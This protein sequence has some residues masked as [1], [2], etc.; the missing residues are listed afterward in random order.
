MVLAGAVATLER[1]DLFISYSRKDSPFV[2]ELD[3]RLQELK[4]KTWVDWDSV[5][6]GSEFPPKIRAGIEGAANFIFVISPDSVSSGWCQLEL[7]HAVENHKRL[8]SILYRPVDPMLLPEAIRTLQWIDFR[9]AVWDSALNTLSTVIDTDRRWLDRH[10]RILVR[11]V[12]WQAVSSD[13]LL[14]R[15]EELQEAVQWLGDAI[16]IKDPRPSPLQL[17]YIQ[18]SQVAQEDERRRWQQLSQKYLAGRLAAESKLMREE[19]PRLLARSVLLAIESLRRFP[20][21]EAHAA[22]TQALSL[23]PRP[24]RRPPHDVTVQAI[25]F[26]PKGS[27]LASADRNGRI[28]LTNLEGLATSEA[29]AHKG[30]VRAMSF[31]PDERFL[32]AASIDGTASVWDLASSKLHFV[33]DHDEAVDT[34]EF[35]TEGTLL[36]TATGYSGHPGVT[37]IWD[38]EQRQQVAVIKHASISRFGLGGH[39]MATSEATRLVLRNPRAGTITIELPHDHVVTAFD[40]CQR[41][42]ILAVV[43]FDGKL[44]LWQQAEQDRVARD[45]VAMAISPIGPV[46]LSPDGSKVAALRADSQIRVWDVASLTEVARIGYEGSVIFCQLAFDPSGRQVAALS[47]EGSSIAVWDIETGRLVGCIEQNQA[48]AMCFSPNGELLATASQDNAAWIWARPDPSAWNWSVVIGPSRSV[49]FSPDGSCLAWTG[50]RVTE[51]GRIVGDLLT[52]WESATGRQLGSFSD[53]TLIENV[54]F[55]PDGRLVATTSPEGPIHVFESM[56][57]TEKPEMISEAQQWFDSPVSIDGYPQ[58][59]VSPDG[60]LFADPV[61]PNP[62][63]ERVPHIVEVRTSADGYALKNELRFDGPP[64]SLAWSPDSQ[65]LASGH[66]DGVVRVWD[67][68]TGREIARVKF[69]IDVVKAL[70]FSPGGEWLASAGYDG[71]LVVWRPRTE[72]LMTEACS[73]LTRNLTLEEWQQY[74]GEEKYEETCPYLFATRQQHGPIA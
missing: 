55:S 23:L 11:A 44:W 8:I 62:G 53:V 33:V 31:S 69:H 47:G 28:K 20:S 56:T 1:F 16:G 34:V 40:V 14:L 48:T 66:V 39:I 72:D 19:S 12:E 49:R 36:L 70:A 24:I 29:F 43:T 73:R 54:A 27:W 46:A 60:S 41:R 3:A 17:A 61:N 58:A 59:E 9:D 38:I 67:V 50:K 30:C 25:A 45:Q 6:P 51:N 5:R 13:S 57:G 4:R 7:A 63:V 68:A 52:L 10:T 65:T 22:L 74:L 71:K 18:A 21:I 26:G 2:R 15:G 35:A 32:A 42:P 64:T 37:K